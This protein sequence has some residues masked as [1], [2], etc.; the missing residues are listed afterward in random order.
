[1]VQSPLVGVSG[2]RLIIAIL[3]HHPVVII[4]MEVMT[5]VYLVDPRAPSH[6]AS[7]DALEFLPGREVDIEASAFGQA[8][9]EDLAHYSLNVRPQRFKVGILIVEAR[10][11]RH[12]RDVFHAALHASSHGATVM[13]VDRGVVAMVNATEDDVGAAVLA[14][15]VK[16]ELNAVDGRTRARPHL[17]FA[18]VL[19]TLQP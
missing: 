3:A 14:E 2:V 10:G 1:M 7:L 8:L 12:G 5:L 11:E 6:A 18:N 4:T 19:P 9:V 15:L 17:S 16:G 13:A